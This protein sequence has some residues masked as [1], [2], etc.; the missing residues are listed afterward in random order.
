MAS[1]SDINSIIRRL[2]VKYKVPAPGWR[3][4]RVGEELQE[5]YDAD[6]RTLVIARDTDSD[7]SGVRHEFLHYV[8]DSLCEK[9][10]GEKIVTWE[11]GEPYA[12]IC[13]EDLAERY[14]DDP[15]ER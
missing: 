14:M 8:C 9:F 11:G 5:W 2:S 7:M 3:F 15:L 12:G 6:T 13:S 1:R 4:A 10:P